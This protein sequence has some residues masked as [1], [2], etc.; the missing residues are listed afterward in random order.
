MFLSLEVSCIKL[1]LSNFLFCIA[2]PPMTNDF[3]QIQDAAELSKKSIQTIR[4][5]IKSKKIKFKR[6]RTPQGFNYMIDRASLYELFKIKD[7]GEKSSVKKETKEVPNKKEKIN[8]KIYDKSNLDINPGDFKA[9]VSALETMVA[10]HSEERQNFI[11]LMNTLQEK[12]FVL[13]NQLNLLKAPKNH[14][15]QFWK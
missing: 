10:K 2:N 11:R 14:W 12:I 9:L 13:E 3:I 4:R 8:Q 15:Y 6:Q 1:N 7:V 5:A